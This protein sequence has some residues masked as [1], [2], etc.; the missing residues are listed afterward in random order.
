MIP[1]DSRLCIVRLNET[2][3]T[4]KDKDTHRGLFIVSVYAPADCSS[5]EVKDEFYMKLSNLLQ[6]TKRSA[7]EMVTGDFYVQVGKL[8]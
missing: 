3:R 7:E 8:S 5:N 1:I 4:P 2:V 6:K